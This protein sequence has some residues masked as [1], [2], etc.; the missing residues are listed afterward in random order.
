[1]ND[2]AVRTV[3][4]IIDAIF[5]KYSLDDNTPIISTGGSMGGLSALIYTRYAKRTPA[6]CAA[7]C[8][9]CDLFFHYTER[10]DLPRTIYHALAHYEMDFEEAKRSISPL[11]QVENMPDIP[12]FVVHCTADTAVNKEKHSDIFVEQMRATNHRVE[13]IAVAG[14]GHCDL[15]PEARAKYEHFIFAHI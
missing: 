11:H 9:V 6:A 3:D 4:E 5:D 14:H 12:Y 13:Y 15:S 8:P 10:V 1:M 7:N 2:V